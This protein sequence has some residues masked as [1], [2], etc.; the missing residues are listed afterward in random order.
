MLENYLD[1]I[2]NMENFVD[3]VLVTDRNA[4]VVYVHEYS[5]NLTTLTEK[6]YIGKNLFEIYPDMDPSASTIIKALKTGETTLNYRNILTTVEGDSFEVIDDTFPIRE[7]GK[8]IGAVCIT[9]SPLRKQAMKALNISTAQAKT[10]RQL[11]TEA[12]IIGRS[13]SIN[14]LRR[15]IRKVAQTASSLLIYGDTGTGKEMVAQSVH[16]GSNRKNRPFLTQNCAAIPSSLLESI[17]FGTV[18]GSYTGAENHAGLFETA[19]GGTVFLDEINSMDIGL[20]A[21][22]LRVLEEKKVTR[23]GSTDSMDVDV[24]IIAAVNKPPLDCI[25]NGTLRADLFYRLG[26]VTLNLPSLTERRDDIELLTKYFVDQYNASM[27]KNIL[28]VSRDVMGVFHTYSWPGNVREL[29]NVIEGAFNLC[30]STVIGLGDLPSYLLSDV[31]VDKIVAENQATI[32]DIQWLGSLK[33][34]MEAYEKY[35]II[36]AIKTHKNLVSA[37]SYLGI[38]RQNLN[39]KINKYK[40]PVVKNTLD[41]AE[42]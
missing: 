36:K 34:N 30:D 16:S 4:D 5:P 25:K 20:Q 39:Q 29:K 13:E 8:I 24:R 17:F 11:F 18:K 27:N 14:T 33:K 42:E 37:A 6:D 21:K 31:E 32:D 10:P 15:Q 9:F 26:S 3:G 38:S 35:M 28:G 2:T 40:I 12:D 41:L 19:D 1:I 22:L 23:I 7:N